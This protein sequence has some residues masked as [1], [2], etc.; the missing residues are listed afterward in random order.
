MF[1]NSEGYADVTAETAI[2]RADKP[3]CA[4]KQ[5]IYI[6]HLIASLAGMEVV[7]RITL[8]DKETGRIWD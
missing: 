3:P 7:G 2:G 1:K 6:L 8:R 4:V 5:V